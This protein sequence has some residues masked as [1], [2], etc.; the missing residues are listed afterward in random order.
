[1]TLCDG[2]FHMCFETKAVVT[3]LLDNSSKNSYNLLLQ[4]QYRSIYFS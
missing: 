1:M 4:T 2:I 3:L